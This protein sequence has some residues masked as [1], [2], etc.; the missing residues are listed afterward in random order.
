VLAHGSGSTPA[1]RRSGFRLAA[2]VVPRR[3]D[4]RVEVDPEEGDEYRG[5]VAIELDL[6]TAVR[7]IEL[8]GVDLRVGK[9]RIATGGGDVPARAEMHP[10]TETISL[11]LARPVGPGPATLHIAFTGKLRDNLRG[12]YGASAQGQRYA[13]TQ[14]EAADARRF[15]PCF[16]E[17]AMKARFRIAVTTR[18]SATVLSNAPIEQQTPAGAGRKTVLFEETPPLSTYLVALAVGAL[19]ASKPVACGKTEIRV[20]HVPGKGALTGFSLEA[21]R[22]CLARLE[23]WFGLPYPY[24]KLDLVAVPDF[25]AGAMENA[26]AVF[27]REN[28]LLL[29]PKA[30]TLAE[31]KRAAEVICHE[32][33]H[34]WYG[35]LV[36]MAWWDDLWLNESFATWMAFEI[37]DD[38]KPE[39]KMWQDFQHH[40]AA[41][42]RLDALASTHPIHCEVRT[43]NDATENFDLI[44]YEKGASVVRMLERYIGPKTFQKGVRAYIREHRESNA[45]AADLW[46]ALAEAA[47]EPVDPVVR[48]WIEQE[49]FPVVSLRRG[50]HAGRSMLTLRQERFVQSARAKRRGDGRAPAKAAPPPRWPVPWVGR[51]A[52]AR[53]RVRVVREVLKG[54]TTRIDLGPG[55]TSFVYGNAD[56]GGFFRVLHD[57]ATLRALAER[58]PLLTAVE[59]MGLVDHQW[60]LVR[61]GR[62]P[63]DSFL[64]LA[65]AFG[66]EREPDVLL[67]LRAPLAFVEDRL[68]DAAG[69][70]SAE[71]VRDWVAACFGPAFLELGWESDTSEADDTRLRRSALIGL[72]GD[73]AEWP[74]ILE[75][76]AERFER[77][78][79]R[80]DAI[81]PNLA[82]PVVLLAAR[83][84]DAAR[85][86]AMLAAFEKAAT[87]QER[88]RFLFALA[89]FRPPKLVDRTLALCLTDRV[90]TQDM[91][92]VLVRLLAN[93]AARERTWAFVQKR[94]SRLSRRMPPMLASRLVDATPALGPKRRREVAAF[95][96]AHPLPTGARAVD[97]ALE[98]FD[99]DAAFCKLAGPDLARWIARG[100][101]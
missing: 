41:A 79:E 52:D 92:F 80:R 37:V 93:R 18:A 24:A 57:A 76:A 30:A 21:A 95:F 59:R 98:R 81:D 68:S 6:A 44:T 86:E 63:I 66:D 20:W 75:A 22:Q 19:E 72:L 39:W 36:T 9:A 40:R 85:Y 83:G 48:P 46:R 50:R 33:A 84:G 29:D 16:D 55:D 54:A 62:A 11:A 77:Y 26:G 64:D 100:S 89:E 60:A 38:W 70:G 5:E 23:K 94:W 71:R 1:R 17:P 4:L 69:R 74:P 51:V 12:L 82:D 35:D 96:R 61:A 99:L 53:G 56:E 7:R 90:P 3:Y 91:A 42:L 31:Q 87:P 28:L 73:V 45:T 32:L 43:P 47:G 27:F 34:M 67:A 14:L 65:G 58:L 88:R 97:Q 101:D 78:L 8:H 13:F 2:E 49:G 25:E 15:F 10:A